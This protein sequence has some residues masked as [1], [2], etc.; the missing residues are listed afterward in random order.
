MSLT[1]MG[2]KMSRACG[3]LTVTDRVAVGRALSQ[4]YLRFLVT[5]GAGQAGFEVTVPVGECIVE[6]LF[7]DRVVIV[8]TVSQH[9][10]SDRAQCTG[11]AAAGD[12]V[13]EVVV[14]ADADGIV[15]V[16]AGSLQ[17]HQAGALSARS[18]LLC[19]TIIL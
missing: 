16:G 1:F 18:A 14:V 10:L 9:A 13:E 17:P 3:K 19:V 11:L 15:G 4:L 8:F 6:A 12:F 5:D 2:V 7:A